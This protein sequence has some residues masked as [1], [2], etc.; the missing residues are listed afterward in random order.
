MTVSARNLTGGALTDVTPA[1]FADWDLSGGETVR[2]SETLEALI[3]EPQDGQGPLAVLA[4]EGTVVGRAS[5][6]LG[7]PGPGGTYQPDS[8]V[9][10]ESFAEADKL[11]LVTGGSAAGLPGFATATDRAALLSVGRM[12]VAAGETA[13]VRFWLLAAD[14]EAEAAARLRDLRD[15]PI[16]PPGPEDEFR[17]EPPF[18]NP[19][20]T[21]EAVMSFPY[22]VPRSARETGRTL[23]FEIYDVAGRRLVQQTH[24]LSP[25]GELPPVVWDGYLAG[26]LE[27]ASGAYLFVFRLDGETRSGRI[28]V[29]H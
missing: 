28:M 14:T 17:I 3:A 7:T 29:V 20:R 25:S 22:T 16:E 15:E 4:S 19:M 23:V 11:S 27:A 9:L 18:P 2:W 24:R 21:G 6:P 10:W 1:M 8:G 5:V 26:D 13:V 12:N